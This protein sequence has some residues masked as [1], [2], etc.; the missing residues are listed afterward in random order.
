[1][2]IGPH[3]VPTFTTKDPLLTPLVELAAPAYARLAR[4]P[5]QKD[6]Q[7]GHSNSEAIIFARTHIC[8]ID[9]AG[10]P[11]ASQGTRNGPC[12]IPLRHLEEFLFHLSP[13]H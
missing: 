3:G 6:S 7:V 1:M 8:R 2:N 9:T 12:Y 5:M 10:P 4:W 13:M 11:R